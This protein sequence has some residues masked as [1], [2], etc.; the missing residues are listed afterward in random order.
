[1]QAPSLRRHSKVVDLTEES[2]D[3]DGVA[4]MSSSINTAATTSSQPVTPVGDDDSGS[5][6]LATSVDQSSIGVDA[7]VA[8]ASIPKI[9]KTLPESDGLAAREL[10]ICDDRTETGTV[11]GDAVLA[12]EATPSARIP[13]LSATN[14]IAANGPSL[15]TQTAPKA[16]ELS[17]NPIRPP[18]RIK[19]ADLGNATPISHHF[20]NDI[21][22]RQYRCPEAILGMEQWDERADVWSIA[23]VVFELLTGEYLFNPKSR[24]GCWGKDDDHVAQISELIGDGFSKEMKTTGRWSREIW[25]SNGQLRHISRLHHWPLKSVMMEKYDHKPEDAELFA[26]FM[27]PMLAI[28]PKKRV[29]AKD[30]LNHPWLQCS[31]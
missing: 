7:R 8:I 25:R 18:I 28:D 10:S 15:L 2:E 4:S 13:G 22:T 12:R 16:T 19:I 30:M 5:L 17:S 1:V 6:T 29:S 31:Q 24:Q 27:E 3:N 9:V 20:T 21:Q 26:S 11:V 23:C 14:P